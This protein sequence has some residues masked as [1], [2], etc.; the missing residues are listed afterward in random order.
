[1]IATQSKFKKSSNGSNYEPTIDNHHVGYTFAISGS[2]Y[3]MVMDSFLP[4]FDNKIF[5]FPFSVWVQSAID[6]EWAYVKTELIVADTKVFRDAE[7]NIYYDS[8][9]NEDANNAYTYSDEDILNDQDQVVGTNRVKTLK[10]GLKS[11]YDIFWES[12]LWDSVM[13]EISYAIV[14]KNLFGITEVV[15]S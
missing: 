5:T 14:Y 3:R 2:N 4:D 6:N 13:P 12:I 15:V 8:G 9:D 11:E 1:M 7:N 10:V